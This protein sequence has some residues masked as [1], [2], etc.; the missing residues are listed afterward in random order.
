MLS[1]EGDRPWILTPNVMHHVKLTNL[2]EKS[3]HGIVS[4]VVDATGPVV[5][6]LDHCAR[7]F[8]RKAMLRI[9]AIKGGVH[10]LALRMYE[11]IS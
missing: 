1:I 9:W 6:P 10:G 8:G 11:R 7:L 5:A 4:P 2:G 3:S